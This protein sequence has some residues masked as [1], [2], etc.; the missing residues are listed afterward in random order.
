MRTS[1]A[2]NWTQSGFLPIPELNRTDADVSIMTLNNRVTYTSEVKDPFFRADLPNG[3]N[4]LIGSWKSSSIL[5]GL[6]CTEQYQFCDP[7]VS[8]G[9]GCTALGSLYDF[10]EDMPPGP[11]QLNS[12]QIAVYKL[13][14]AMMYS[15]AS[16]VS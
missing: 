7:K 11:I 5:T 4:R 13:L 3:A 1:Y 14:R 2:K 10:A 8:G 16:T 9:S 12:R 6:A 15:C